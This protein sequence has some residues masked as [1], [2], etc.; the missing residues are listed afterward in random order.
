LEESF[1]LGHRRDHQVGSVSLF[2]CDQRHLIAIQIHR[3][4]NLADDPLTAADTPFNAVFDAPV[5]DRPSRFANSF[6]GYV[7]WDDRT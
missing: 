2:I 7:E 1:E 4:R 6:G 3:Q 5:A